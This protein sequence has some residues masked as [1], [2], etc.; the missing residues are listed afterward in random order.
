MEDGTAKEESPEEKLTA[1]EAELRAR[2]T[3]SDIF[4]ERIPKQWE[5]LD[6]DLTERKT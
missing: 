3:G 4:S 1:E 2:M 5:C 6:I